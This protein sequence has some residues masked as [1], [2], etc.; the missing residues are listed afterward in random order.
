MPRTREVAEPI[1]RA[2]VD[3]WAVYQLPDEEW[4]ARIRTFEQYW[5]SFELDTF[6]HVLQEGNEADRLVA[7]FALGYLAY[8]ETKE[9]LVPFL[10]SS[11]GKERWA[12][13]IV[14]PFV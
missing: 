11:V 9:L 2:F 10:S 12:S 6:K 14:V 8:E 4:E 13:A 7:L 5:G 1:R 3:A